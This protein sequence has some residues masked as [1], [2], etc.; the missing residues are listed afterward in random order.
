MVELRGTRTAF[1]IFSSI[2]SLSREPFPEIT[3]E[4]VT[5]DRCG[6]QSMIE[7]NGDYMIRGLQPVC[8]Y[9]VPAK[10]GW[11]VGNADRKDLP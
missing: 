5:D 11:D 9:N 7:V 6:S 4:A 3:V 1:S 10:D 8:Q 2:T